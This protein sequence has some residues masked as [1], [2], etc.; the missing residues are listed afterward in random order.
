MN[1]VIPPKQVQRCKSGCPDK[2][3][4]MADSYNDSVDTS[5]SGRGFWD[6]ANHYDEVW[7]DVIYNSNVDVH[8]G[9]YADYAFSAGAGVNGQVNLN[10]LNGDFSLSL[11][12]HGNVGWGAS[13]GIYGGMGWGSPIANGLVGGGGVGSKIKGPLGGEYSN[14]GGR[15]SADISAGFGG[16]IAGHV[17]QSKTY[18][19]D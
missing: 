15:H 18:G 6:T 17:G 14:Y 16:I 4:R 11:G 3:L 7:G 2:A 8:V 13:A 19:V 10:V 1:P 9:L 12:F 5:H